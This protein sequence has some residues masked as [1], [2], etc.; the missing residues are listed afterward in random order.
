MNIILVMIIA[1]S[2]V[3]ALAFRLGVRRGRKESAMNEFRRGFRT[4]Y[5]RARKDVTGLFS[6]PDGELLMRIRDLRRS[7][8][9]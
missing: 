8:G 6:L 1:C 9:K 3:Y 7:A 2:L 5:D 4:G